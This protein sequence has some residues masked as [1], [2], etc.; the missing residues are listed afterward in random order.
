MQ[1]HRLCQ[2]VL[3]QLGPTLR[4]RQHRRAVQCLCFRWGRDTARG[5]RLQLRDAGKERRFRLKGA[6]E[7]L[8]QVCLCLQ[9][10]GAADGELLHP[11]LEALDD[12]ACGAKLLVHLLEQAGLKLVLRLAAGSTVWAL[13]SR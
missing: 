10:F 11:G 3:A 2:L 7:S 8:L 4:L 6:C 9:Q 1:R 12:T 13:G 5:C